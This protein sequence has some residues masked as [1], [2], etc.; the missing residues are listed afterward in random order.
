MMMPRRLAAR[1]VAALMI[2]ALMIPAL[3]ARSAAA[4]GFSMARTT[5]QIEVYAD[6]GI[7]WQTQSL[8]VIARGN[9][10]A[11]R[12]TM[13]VT[14]H[15]L[16]AHYREGANGDEI[17][18]LDAEGDVVITSPTETATGTSATY[19]L[20][21]A[22]FVMRGNPARMVTPTDTFT[23]NDTLEYWE[24]E[25]MAVARGDG[26]A[27]Q[28]GRSVKADVLTARF[29]DGAQGQLELK[30]ADA[31]GNVVLVTPTER[32]TGERGDYN[33]ETSIATVS[34]SVKIVR[35]GNELNGG[36]AHV[37][38]DTGISKLFGAAPGGKGDGRVRG[39]FTP[40]KDSQG[41]QK[42]VFPGAASPPPGPGTP[43]QGTRQ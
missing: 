34:G 7:E 23:A 32:I 29:K 41:R 12:G 39:V 26:T 42:A 35:E 31:Y 6:Q 24:T 27:V 19:D 43:N 22:I 13:T 20:D 3:G 28:K 2:L 10:K 15:T 21:K 40:E 37:N 14:A 25:R 4:Q 30:R 5:D 1:S 18:R 8:R 36:Y 17:W 11:V 16:T 33:L 38:L 9:A